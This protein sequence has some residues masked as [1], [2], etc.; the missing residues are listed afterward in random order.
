MSNRKNKSKISG[1]PNQEDV[2]K[3]VGRLDQVMDP[4]RDPIN[5][6]ETDLQPGET[7][8]ESAYLES[9]FRGR[10]EPTDDIICG[11]TRGFKVVYRTNFQNGEE[12][13]FL[14]TN[15][16]FHRL[17]EDLNLKNG[18][19]FQFYPGE[20]AE[21]STDFTVDDMTKKTCGRRI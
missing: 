18:H 13:N 12:H 7:M 5:V 14:C 8:T 2:D 21:D 3:L 20:T 6:E 1:S 4:P 16:A 10:L 19:T 11:L 9:L 17:K 15:W